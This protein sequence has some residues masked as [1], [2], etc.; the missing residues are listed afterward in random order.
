MTRSYSQTH[1][2]CYWILYCSQTHLNLGHVIINI[3]DITLG[4]GVATKSKN[5]K[6][7]FIEKSNIFRSYFLKK[8]K[9]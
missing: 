2:Q 3:I 7:N 4:L 9:K 1:V 6:Y 5:L 8:Y